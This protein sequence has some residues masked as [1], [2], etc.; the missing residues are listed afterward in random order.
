MLFVPDIIGLAVPPI[1]PVLVGCI[2]AFGAFGA[3]T[4][5]S[6]ERPKQPVRFLRTGAV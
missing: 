2:G 3:Y 6:L 5:L 1:P 4:W